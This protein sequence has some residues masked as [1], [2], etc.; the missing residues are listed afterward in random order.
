MYETR[1]KRLE[2]DLNAS[3]LSVFFL[4]S[5]LLSVQ[6]IRSSTTLN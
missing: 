1:S 6:Y 2:L 5:S 4:G 3:L